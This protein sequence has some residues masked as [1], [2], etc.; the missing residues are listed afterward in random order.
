MDGA[1]ILIV[2]VVG[3]ALIGIGLSRREAYELAALYQ[4]LARKRG[5]RVV[6]H[7]ASYPELRLTHRGRPVLVKATL[8][9]SS[10]RPRAQATLVRAWLDA[11]TAPRFEVK[12]R[13][14]V[15]KLERMLG[16]SL[17]PVPFEG[18]F[19]RELDA[20]AEDP[21]FL[22]RALVASQRRRLLDLGRRWPGVAVRL[23]PVRPRPCDVAAEASASPEADAEQVF[24][25]ER[26]AVTL[27]VDEVLTELADYE[28]L[29]E[30]FLSILD[31][32]E[33]A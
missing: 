20:W 15:S 10:G 2:V 7:F 16:R 22:R 23:A 29:I 32:V 13:S 8:P 24:L 14:L 6:R 27:S 21:G 19:A 28:R 33:A 12:R 4:T 9:S 26:P 11:G 5:G 30:T 25:A 31:D 17:Q 3:L 18:S 1:T